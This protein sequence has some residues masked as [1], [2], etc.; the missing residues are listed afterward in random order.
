MTKRNKSMAI[1]KCVN[2]LTICGKLIEARNSDILNK[3]TK[4]HYGKCNTCK[5]F[6]F[7][8]EHQ[9][10]KKTVVKKEDEKYFNGSKAIPVLTD[11]HRV[12]YTKDTK[13]NIQILSEQNTPLNDTPHQKLK[14]KI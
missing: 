1:T 13:G 14:L 7:K 4:L 3:L 9:T 5:N 8:I 12:I 2:Y 11:E 10:M 6:D